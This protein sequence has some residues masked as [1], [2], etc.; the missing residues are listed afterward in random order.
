VAV[1]HR[2]QTALLAGYR[3][4]P[5][6]VK[7]FLIRRA[8]PSFHVGAVAVVERADGALLLVRQS[9]R[10]GGWAFPGGLLRRGETPYDGARRETGEELGIDVVLDPV[11]VV[12]IDPGE[13]RVD[14]IFRATLADG[15][16]DPQAGGWSAEIVEVRWFRPDG[17][18]SLL[19]ETVT[20]L[21]ELGRAFPPR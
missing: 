10:R 12:V 8:T 2:V 16:P 14:V 19:P 4:L 3:R 15:S 6:V 1:P 17:L 7:L 11:P 5:G 20:A 21:V 18:P 9:Y 13:R